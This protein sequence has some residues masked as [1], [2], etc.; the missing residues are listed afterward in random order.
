MDQNHC[1]SDMEDDDGG[2]VKDEAMYGGIVLYVS[3]PKVYKGGI[4]FVFATTSLIL[5]G[6]DIYFVEAQHR[7]APALPIVGLLKAHS[8]SLVVA[9]QLIYYII[10]RNLT[11]NNIVFSGAQV[12]FKSY[13]CAFICICIFQS[14]LIYLLYGC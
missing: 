5:R 4:I 2:D 6:P 8:C 3:Q 13:E 7:L 10:A 12:E 9:F 1:E 14:V 11:V